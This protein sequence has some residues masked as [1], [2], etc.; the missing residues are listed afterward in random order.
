MIREVKLLLLPGLLLPAF[1]LF[2]KIFLLHAV[3]IRTQKDPTSL[4]Y[5]YKYELLDKLAEEFSPE[6]AAKRKE[7]AERARES[8]EVVLPH[9]VLIVIGSSRMLFFDYYTFRRN[10]PEW[11]VYNFSVPVNSPAYYAY[12]LERIYESGVKPDYLI[13]ESDPF[14]FNEYSPGFRR[15]NLQYSFDLR[16]ILSNFHR[17]DRD[18]V[19]AF[20][21]RW[22]FAG[23]KYPPHPDR[24][25]MLLQGNDRFLPL[26]LE[27]DRYTRKTNGC[28][29]S[30]IPVPGWFEKDFAT[31][32]IGSEGTKGWLYG[33]YAESETQWSFFKSALALARQNKTPFLIIRPQVSRPMQRQLEEDERIVYYTQSWK[34]RLDAIRGK[35]PLLDLSSGEPYYCNAYVD[36]AHMA[37][38]CYD[39]VLDEAMKRYEDARAALISQ[40]EGD[41]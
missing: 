28:G 8:G 30:P 40:Q 5:E 32:A 29:F 35:H 4:Y 15:S 2:D 27:T 26:F 39:P 11:E 20:L 1:F 7:A 31:L 38:E 9:R 22:L 41:L 6:N 16:F 3:R 34:R 23:M 36:G 19:S 17:L 13:L 24:L 21:G 37:M 12:I 18:D 14:Q 33:N 25:M 10:H